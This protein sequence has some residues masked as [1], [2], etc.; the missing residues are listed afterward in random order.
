MLGKMQFE[1]HLRYF[2]GIDLR[3]ETAYVCSIQ[4]VGFFFCYME[5]VY[6]YRW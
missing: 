5:A 6:A 2:I 3:F 1:L 4:P